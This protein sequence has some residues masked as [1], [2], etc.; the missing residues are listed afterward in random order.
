MKGTGRPGVA[1]AMLAAA[2]LAA[3]AILQAAA[4]TAAAPP[5][6]A[7]GNDP[8]LFTREQLEEDTRRLAAVLRDNHPDPYI[9]GGGK[10]AF[11]RRMQEVL[12]S[13]PGSGMTAADFHDLLLPFV[14]S[15]RD[16]HTGIW[17]PDRR[18]SSEPGLP[19][20]FRVIG[21]ELCVTGAPWKL[22]E[23]FRGALL[24]S[25]AGVPCDEL[26][27]RQGDLEGFDN[28]Y[29]NLRHLVKNLKTAERLRNLIPEWDGT[30]VLAVAFRSAAGEPLEWSGPPGA[31]GI[32]PLEKTESVIETPS[33]EKC[34]IVYGFL[35][36][37][38]APALLR[39]ESMVTYREAFEWLR[40]VGNWNDRREKKARDTYERFHGSDAPEKIDDV[41]A[42][43]PSA[44]EIF[45][46]LV[47]AMK[48]RGTKTLIVD[49]RNNGGGNSIMTS[50]LPYFFEGREN[51][52]RSYADHYQIRRYGPLY[53]ENSS[54]LSLERV[55]RDR[56][57]PL[58]V[59][60]YSFQSERIWRVESKTPA[61]IRAEDLEWVREN[62]GGNTTF[63]AEMQSLAYEAYYRPETIVV[64]TSAETYSA[65][66][67][68]A[69]R[70]YRM[71]A[72]IV[73]T[74]SSQSGNC[75][76]DAITTTLDNTGIG[77]ALSSKEQIL[78]PEDEEKG[79]VLMPDHLLTYEKLA[80][81][82]FDP[83]AELLLALE[84]LGLR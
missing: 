23:R 68:M 22:D 5:A 83:N 20:R 41:I 1:P 49:L 71:G 59:G 12:R 84:A 73:G 67:D 8:P 34:D 60:D 14:A 52:V 42:G 9:R 77:L 16:G 26:V 55:N 65:G 61:A 75:F 43:I 51:F 48:K 6:P 32:F 62:I 50:Y 33:V 64:L 24:E 39:I 31:R 7:A 17:L 11:H 4:P 37:P 46:D 78:F 66:F 25:V 29:H 79:R 82:N 27:A 72:V 18:E 35:D 30:S 40:S 58:R 56:E 54:R 69:V 70:L 15:V 47:I 53:F 28:E 10:V 45:R 74:P 38:G 21:S 36:A 63:A 81:L 2:L 44:T 19:F 80:E 57:L 13:I 76:I 3:A